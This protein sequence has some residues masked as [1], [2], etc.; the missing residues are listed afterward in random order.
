VTIYSSRITVGTAATQLI[1]PSNQTQTC[2]LLNAG[3][4]IV[5]IGDESV[6]TTAF[7]LPLIPDNPNVSRTFFQ[8]DLQPGDSIWGITAAGTAPVNVW[9]VRK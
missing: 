7:G 2:A 6:T 8:T 9:A 1:P 5:R 4:A 3:T